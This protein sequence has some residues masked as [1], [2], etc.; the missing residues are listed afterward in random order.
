MGI[1]NF[2]NQAAVHLVSST[3]DGG[4]PAASPNN[5]FGYGR[6]DIQAAVNNVMQLTSVVS[7]KNHG[8][9]PFD[10]A[11]P[12]SG[13]AGVECRN[14]GGNHTLVFSFDGPVANGAASV[15]G[16][17][18]TISGSPSFAGNTMT[19]NLSGVT[20][21]Q[22]LTVTLGNVTNGASRMLPTTTVTV[23]T[24][25]GDTNGDRSVNAGD[26]LQTRGRAGQAIDTTN[27]R[28]DVNLDGFLNSGDTTA[29]RA[30][31]GNFVP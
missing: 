18:G 27:F 20:D 4:G 3:C 29:V 22:A 25:I 13:A 15:S 7:R 5:T 19:V 26:A 8:G 24:L 1:R 12:L 21:A 28:S 10:I 6:I 16:G 11:L 23:K 17:T 31:S 30:R 14:S 2:I 9:T